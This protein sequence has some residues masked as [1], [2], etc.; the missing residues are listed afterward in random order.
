MSNP[1]EAVYLTWTW[2]WYIS[3]TLFFRII[4]KPWKYK[5]YLHKNPARNPCQLANRDIYLIYEVLDLSVSSLTRALG[6][7][8]KI[9]S[10]K[11][12]E[13]KI[14]PKFNLWLSINSISV[15][16]CTTVFNAYIYWR[17]VQPAISN[18]SLIN[19]GKLHKQ[20]EKFMIVMR[21]LINRNFVIWIVAPADAWQFKQ[22]I[23]IPIE[24]VCMTLAQLMTSWSVINWESNTEWIT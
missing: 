11:F 14:Q 21:G 19:K 6:I 4:I 9:L 7:D 16:I 18:F 22:L 15:A 10:V 3:S 8:P 20:L 23:R 1:C 17:K 24:Y 5:R 12:Q 13:I 2:S